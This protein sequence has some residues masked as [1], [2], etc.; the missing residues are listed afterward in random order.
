[1]EGLF[2]LQPPEDSPDSAGSL[3]PSSAPVPSLLPPT[4]RSAERGSR[5]PQILFTSQLQPAERRM[6]SQADQQA[7]ALRR[8]RPSQQRS[9]SRS[10]RAA[11]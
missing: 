11:C 4:D 10:H 8:A 1:M 6:P 3:E 7:D 5:G 9:V 2:P